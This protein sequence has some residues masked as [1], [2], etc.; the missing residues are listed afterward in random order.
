MV[1][2]S[3][4]RGLTLQHS[5]PAEARIHSQSNYLEML[6]VCQSHNDP[7]G[8]ATL[9]IT[10]HQPNMLYHKNYHHCII[11]FAHGDHSILIVVHNM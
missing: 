6:I 11:R 1:L 5:A 4:G 3:E 9:H 10:P 7:D 8:L 2:S